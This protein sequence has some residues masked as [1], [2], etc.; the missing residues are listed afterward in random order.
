MLAPEL[1]R[2]KG[3]YSTCVC[4]VGPRK[5]KE[6]MGDVIRARHQISSLTPVKARRFQSRPASHVH[7]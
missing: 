4:G 7:A 5:E 2:L 6:I 1:S 3:A